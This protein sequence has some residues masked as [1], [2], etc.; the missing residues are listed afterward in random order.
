MLGLLLPSRCAVCGALGATVCDTCDARLVSLDGVGCARCGAPGPWPL[1]RCAECSGRRLAFAAARAAI[2]YDASAR[3]LVRAWKEGGRRDVA[4]W[5]AIRVVDTLARP[6]VQ[7]I[8]PVPGDRDRTL[9][10]GHVTALGLARRLA[11]LW[12]IPLEDALRRSGG[13]TR[14]RGLGAADRRANVRGA[15]VARSA[16]PR[17]VCLVDDVYTTG[18]TATACAT[19]ARRKGADLVWV[20]TLAR[21]V[22]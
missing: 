22:R 8:V 15:F 17:R 16:L 11:T 3:A 18:S 9:V 19:A 12:D 10:R 6:D 20:V 21:A 7:A 1:R 14:Q 5:A 4:A 13:S 2:A